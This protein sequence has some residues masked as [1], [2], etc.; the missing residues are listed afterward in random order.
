MI[1]INNT[2]RTAIDEKL[3]RQVAEDTLKY[4][5][6]T[7]FDLSIAFVGETVMRRLNL[8][9]RGYDKV[10]D[11]LSFDGEGR[12]LGE[13]ILCYSKI[14][15]QAP[16]YKQTAEKELVFILVHGILHLLGHTDDK[17]DERL[18]MISLGEL[19]IKKISPEHASASSEC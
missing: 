15:R 5:K 13:L 6:K 16:R 3:V 14:A 4:Y 1:E 8:Q 7:S 12:D 9:S 19:I 18:A 11:V 2:T 10:T 17:E